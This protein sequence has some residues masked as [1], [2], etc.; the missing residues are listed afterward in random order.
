M[1]S[2]AASCWIRASAEDGGKFEAADTDN[3]PG[4][5]NG[6]FFVCYRSKTL[7]YHM[8][9]GWVLFDPLEMS[10]EELN[11]LCVGKKRG[12]RDSHQTYVSGTNEDPTKNEC[13][14]M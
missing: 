1:K 9:G 12:K 10:D 4:P 11:P 5:D 2:S 7:R 6:K 13:E 3:G 8:G 14:L